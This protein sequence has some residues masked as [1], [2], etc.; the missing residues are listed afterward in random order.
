MR[1]V[2]DVLT[3]I[4]VFAAGAS[5]GLLVGRRRWRDV[6]DIEDTVPMALDNEDQA[7]THA[8]RAW[9]EAHGR[10][11]ADWLVAD[12]LRLAARLRRSGTRRASR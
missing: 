6:E 12:K 1:L 2:V 10:P 9:A 7:M 3:L 11:G 4:V 5:A 8:A